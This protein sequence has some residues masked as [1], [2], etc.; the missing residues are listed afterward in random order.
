MKLFLW[1]CRLLWMLSW[2]HSLGLLTMSHLFL[3]S[4][5]LHPWSLSA[6][7]IYAAVNPIS[8]VLQHQYL[9]FFFSINYPPPFV[10][11]APFSNS[12][13]LLFTMSIHWPLR[14]INLWSAPPLLDPVWRRSWQ[15]DKYQQQQK[16]GFNA[17]HS[18]NYLT[19]ISSIIMGFK[20]SFQPSH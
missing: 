10:P 14:A 18:F 3:S 20:W 11:P 1:P 13:F 5:F 2:P 16:V 9:F 7:L 8:P 12:S 4:L 15:A 6:I 17:W 19:S